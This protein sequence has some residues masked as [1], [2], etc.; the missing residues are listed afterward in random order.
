[1][2]NEY[3]GKCHALC[4]IDR[5]VISQVYPKIEEFIL[6]QRSYM[7]KCHF[8]LNNRYANK[9]DHVTQLLMG[10][11]EKFVRLHLSGKYHYF[12]LPKG[13]GSNGLR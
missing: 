3:L 1:M 11:F 7:G 5:K 12:I 10:L 2:G 9:N 8:S 6:L 13:P 4:F